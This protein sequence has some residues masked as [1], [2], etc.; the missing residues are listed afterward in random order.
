VKYIL[1][2]NKH[3]G[4]VKTFIGPLEY[5]KGYDK[6]LVV[7][8]IYIRICN[9]KIACWNHFFIVRAFGKD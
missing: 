8:F 6:C 4:V 9:S 5:T 2:L 7:S 3:L 1:I